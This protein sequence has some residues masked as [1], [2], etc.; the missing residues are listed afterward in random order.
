[1]VLHRHCPV[2]NCQKSICRT[3]RRHW[4]F[5]TH[6]PEPPVMGP[7]L[8]THSTVPK[9][10]SNQHQPMRTIPGLHRIRVRM[11][12][13]HCNRKQNEK[14][15]STN[16][17]LRNAKSGDKVSLIVWAAPETRPKCVVFGVPLRLLLMGSSLAF[18]YHQ[19]YI[20]I[21]CRTMWQTRL[22][23][24]IQILQL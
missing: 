18:I 7:C 1:M 16:R 17:Q 20:L 15:S 2:T 4:I 3:Y 11:H 5:Q 12:G 19:Q 9:V 23:Q 13:C 6:F 22:R 24:T 14:R 10:P 8:W 21:I